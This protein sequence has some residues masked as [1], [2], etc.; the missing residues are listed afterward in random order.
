[1]PSK[2]KAQQRFMAGVASGNITPPKGLN[3]KTAN[4]FV[5]A[6]P[7]TKNLPEK[8]KPTKNKK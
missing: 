6:T 2:S 7:T 8:V 5:K 1:M 4:E 3:K